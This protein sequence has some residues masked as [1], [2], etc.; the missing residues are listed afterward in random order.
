MGEE[1]VVKTDGSY[2]P[3]GRDSS[4]ATVSVSELGESEPRPIRT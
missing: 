4:E 2:F 1:G 3:K